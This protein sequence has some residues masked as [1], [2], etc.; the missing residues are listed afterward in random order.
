MSEHLPK[1]WGK[2][3]LTR[4]FENVRKN[5]FATHV[6]KPDLARDCRAVEELFRHCLSGSF[7]SETA[8]SMPFF[9]RAHSAFLA[10]IGIVWGAQLAEAQPVLRLCLEY[11]GYGFYIGEDEPR[12]DRWLARGETGKSRDRVRKEFG[13]GK[14]RRAIEAADPQLGGQYE[15]LYQRLVDLGGHPNERALS[16]GMNRRGNGDAAEYSTIYLHGDDDHLETTLFTSVQ[17]GLVVLHLMQL[18]F[19]A[20]FR[21]LGLDG[22]LALLRSRY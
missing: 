6:H 8:F 1:E 7:D 18:V 11:G 17:V 13:H 12:L 4:Y 9:F 16:L 22:A 10:A 2:D 20:Q 15:T 19:P 21:L 5:Q 14:I 3:H